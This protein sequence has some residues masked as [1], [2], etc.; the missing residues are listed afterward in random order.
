MILILISNVTTLKCEAK[1]FIPKF[2]TFL[3]IIKFGDDDGLN[4][5]TE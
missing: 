1:F 3:E 2:K 5:S 4:S